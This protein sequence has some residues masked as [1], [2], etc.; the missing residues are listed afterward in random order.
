MLKKSVALILLASSLLMGEILWQPSYRQAREEAVKTKRPMM[1][2]LVSHTCRWCRKLESRTLNNPQVVDFVNDNFVPVIVYREE[3]NYP[4]ER[5]HSPYVPATFFLTPDGKEIMKPTVGYWE[6]HDY[7]SD[8]VMA[9]RK[10][11]TLRSPR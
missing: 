2:I 5:I 11:K 7:M 8:L 9:A 1:V 3:G 10:F 6:P 4:Q